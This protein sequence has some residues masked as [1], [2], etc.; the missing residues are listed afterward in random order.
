MLR[1][2]ASLFIPSLFLCFF[3][4]PYGVFAE[5]PPTTAATD[6]AA[7][8]K[9]ISQEVSPVEKPVEKK[10]E[11][12][13]PAQKTSQRSEGHLREVDPSKIKEDPYTETEK[14]RYFL[15]LQEKAK[16]SKYTP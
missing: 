8:K 7:Q 3:V 6:Q 16:K 13:A 15:E 5:D 10:E 1:L 11:T 2:P 9:E 14:R 12:P 4:G